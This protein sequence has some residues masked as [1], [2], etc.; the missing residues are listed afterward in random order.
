MSKARSYR[1]KMIVLGAA[2]FGAAVFAGFAGSHIL[3]AK[4][5]MGSPWLVLIL[6]LGLTVVAFA[7]GLPWWRKLDD[8]QRTGQ[9]SA[10]YWGGQ[11]GGLT[12]LLA[13]VAFTGKSDY[14]RGALA[15]LVGEFIG[16]SIF[17]LFWRLRSRGLAE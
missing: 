13:L 1:S 8:L 16:F 17:W 10:W 2:G 12:V 15:L 11:T 4:E 3:R 14:S 6:L 7:A 9:L 5:S